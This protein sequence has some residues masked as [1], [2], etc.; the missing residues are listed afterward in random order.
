LR[1]IFGPRQDKMLREWRKLHNEEL[2]GLYFLPNIIQVITSRR[3]TWGGGGI[4]GRTGGGGMRIGFWKGDLRERD[5]LENLVVNGRI[6][7]EM[8]WEDM[9]CMDLDQNRDSL[10]VLMHGIVT[11][12]FLQNAEN[13]FSG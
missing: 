1:R 4:W 7:L 8:G 6:I 13:F 5:H 11:F 9:Y 10:Q 3:M 12:R 2:Y